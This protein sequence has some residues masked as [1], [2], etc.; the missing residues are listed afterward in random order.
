MA[1]KGYDS[2]E[3]R[4]M[5]SGM[6]LKSRIMHKTQKNRKLTERERAVKKA[7]SK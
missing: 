2:T 5:L 3:N 1:D 7:V 6:K 4:K